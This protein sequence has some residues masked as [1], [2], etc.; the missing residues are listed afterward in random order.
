MPLDE[1]EDTSYGHELDILV[2][3]I[4]ALFALD[5]LE[6][7]EEMVVR[8]RAAAHVETRRRGPF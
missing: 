7:V 6:E 2:E 4:N 5:A 1:G 3:L 8:F